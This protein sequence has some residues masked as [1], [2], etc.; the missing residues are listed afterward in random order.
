MSIEM[1]LSV[2]AEDRPGLVEALAGVISANSGNWVDSAMSRLGGEFAGILRISVPEE[3]MASLESGLKALGKQDIAVAIRKGGNEP[4]LPGKK[5][6]LELVGQDQTGIV[7][8]ITRILAGRNV[9]VEELHTEVFTGSMTGEAMFSAHAEI[10]LPVEL[11]F[12][13]LREAL[14]DI[15]Q[16]IM[17]DIELTRAENSG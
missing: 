15:A 6:R 11:K 5:A 1:V 3:N 10:V 12:D 8:E 13:D 4:P 14:E 9:N 2:M 7:L 17:V 16:D